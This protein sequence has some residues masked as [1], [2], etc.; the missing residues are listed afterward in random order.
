MKNTVTGSS[1]SSTLILGKWQRL[2]AGHAGPGLTPAMRGVRTPRQ[3]EP[4]QQPQP[5]RSPPS[6]PPRSGLSGPPCAP[7]SPSEAE[8]QVRSFCAPWQAQPPHAGG[9]DPGAGAGR[10][11]LAAQSPQRLGLVLLFQ[12]AQTRSRSSLQMGGCLCSPHPAPPPLSPASPTPSLTPPSCERVSRESCSRG[13][14]QT[15]A[16]AEDAPAWREREG[17]QRPF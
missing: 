10:M 12:E 15:Q 8:G 16:Q 6:S 11:L 5:R 3:S 2:P 14:R 9:T 17:A 1:P 13:D 7:P 4:R